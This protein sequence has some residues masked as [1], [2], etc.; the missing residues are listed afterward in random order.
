ML[1]DAAPEEIFRGYSAKHGELANT[2]CSPLHLLARGPQ[3]EA[4][5]L[6][7]SQVNGSRAAEA[8]ELLLAAYPNEEE[9]RRTLLECCNL[10]GSYEGGW[11]TKRTPPSV[12]RRTSRS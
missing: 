2:P 4:K 1:L 3:E 9:Q 10:G 8:C 12:T 11:P 5:R 6:P 7:R